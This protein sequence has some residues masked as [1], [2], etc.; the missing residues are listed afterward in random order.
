MVRVA[1]TGMGVISAI[2]LNAAD[3]WSALV[4]GRS[5]IGPIESV[6]RDKL[7]FKNAAEVRGFD[8]LAHFEEKQIDFIDRFAQFLVVAAR[9]ASRDAGIE[10]TD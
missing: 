3:F 5:G 6:D 8:P 10:W 2:G 9:E 7:R 1:I 4:A